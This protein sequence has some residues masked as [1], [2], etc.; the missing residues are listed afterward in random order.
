MFEILD[1][2]FGMSSDVPA[3]KVHAFVSDFE[4]WIWVDE[5]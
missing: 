2:F 4:F 1:G 3:F 5:Y